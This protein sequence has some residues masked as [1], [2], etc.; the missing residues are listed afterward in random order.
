MSDDGQW[1]IRRLLLWTTDYLRRHA[2]DSARL[3]A[4]VLLANV[5]KCERIELYTSFDRV[6]EAEQLAA[7]RELVRRRAQGTPVAYLVGYREFH[8]LT[9]RV[10][11]DVLIPRPE[12]EFVVI[13]LLDLVKQHRSPDRPVEIADVGTGSGVLAICAAK[14]VQP[15]RVTAVDISRPA[16][17]VARANAESHGV[18]DSIEFVESDLLAELPAD[19]CFDF[20]ISN[21]PYVREAEYAKLSRDVREHEPRL[22]LVGGPLG[23][24]VTAR[25]VPQAA[26]RLRQ[27][28]WLL[29][30][31]GPA[32]AADVGGLIEADGRFDRASTIKDLNGLGRVV[33]ARRR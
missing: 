15:C 22:A 4:E 11:P 3:D 23:T 20:V 33:R 29:I 24:E 26:Q 5:L 7:F 13:A 1:T 25:L 2:A 12:T 14:Y 17:V 9:F 8:S 19:Q 32:T 30:E 28:G 16:L 10:T 27:G 21:P 18:A 31:V 6:P